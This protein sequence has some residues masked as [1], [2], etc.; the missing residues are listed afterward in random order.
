MRNRRNVFVSAQKEI[1]KK[2]LCTTD[3]EA[4]W[5]EVAVRYLM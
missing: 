4:E 1:K 3:K 5:K 2:T